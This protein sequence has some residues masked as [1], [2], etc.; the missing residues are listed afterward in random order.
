MVCSGICTSGI[1]CVLSIA[2]AV[3]GGVAVGLLGFY[4]YRRK[5]KVDKPPATQQ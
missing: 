1:W 4:L 5:K 3:I 2:G